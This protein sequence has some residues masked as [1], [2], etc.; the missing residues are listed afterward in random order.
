MLNE[1]KIQLIKHQ[2][3]KIKFLSSDENKHID[4]TK[5]AATL[6]NDISA[7]IA[8]KVDSTFNK[9][10]CASADVLVN[11]RNDVFFWH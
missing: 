9:Y 2:G 10:N 4:E 3:T 11:I 5:F 1:V 7:S 8:Y 6:E